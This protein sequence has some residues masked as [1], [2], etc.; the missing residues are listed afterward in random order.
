M[1][2]INSIGHSQGES[3][4]ITADTQSKVI[5]VIKEH[6]RWRICFH[7]AEKSLI[8]QCKAQCR[9]IVSC[10]SVDSKDLA[11][12]KK[13]ADILY[14]AIEGKGE[15]P[16][17][18][19]MRSFMAPLLEARDVNRKARLYHERAMEK[20]AHQLDV[21][22]W[23]EKVRGFG[24]LGLAQIIGE[25]GDL[26]HY[27]NPAKL[28]KRLGLAVIEG[29]AQRR[30]A[31]AEKAKLH[32]FNPRRRAIM[33]CIGDSMIKAHGPYRE[34][35]LKRKEY[36]AQKL[37]ESEGGRKIIWHRRAQR[38]AEKRLLR[39]LWNTWKK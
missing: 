25:C 13:E 8:N 30:V 9:R 2:S 34:I 33:F 17:A 14:R 4:I 37:P 1:E 21:F 26:G 15:H 5:A 35:Y 24:P 18:D 38:Y 11:A 27:P 39:D 3:Q 29:K 7:K 6:H 31:D 10:H 16:L 22:A 36:E 23:V 20:L 19:M 12:V 32:G 28:W